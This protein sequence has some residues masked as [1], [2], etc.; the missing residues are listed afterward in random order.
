MFLLIILFIYIPA[1][2]PWLKEMDVEAYWV[3]D[4]LFVGLLLFRNEKLSAEIGR[5]SF[6]FTSNTYWL[7]GVLNNWIN[8]AIVSPQ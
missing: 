6:I 8:G 4:A 2:P 7:R 5:I 1:I 3:P